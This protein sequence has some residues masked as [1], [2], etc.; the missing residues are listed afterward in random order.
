MA[1]KIRTEFDY[2]KAR[3]EAERMLKVIERDPQA[4]RWISN[5][6]EL[7]PLF[8]SLAISTVVLGEVS[9]VLMESNKA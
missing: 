4:P 3:E 7:V 5:I 1:D 8:Y 6:Q 2:K 9:K